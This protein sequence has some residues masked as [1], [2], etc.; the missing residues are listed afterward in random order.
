MKTPSPLHIAYDAKRAFFNRSGLGNYSRDLIRL[1]SQHYPDNEYY[2]FKPKDEERIPFEINENTSVITPQ[3][4]ISKR[5]ASLWRMLG[6]SFVLKNHPI[7]IYHGLSHDLP[8]R[9]NKSSVKS[10]VTIHDCIYKRFPKLYDRFSPFVYTLKQKYACKMADSIIA[11]SEQ[12][13]QDIIFYY[14]VPEEKIKVVYQGCNKSFYHPKTDEEKEGIKA[15]YQLP[16][17]FILNV[18]TIEERKN[19]LGILKALVEGNI[20]MPVVALGPKTKYFETVDAYA[21]QHK[22]DV[23]FIHN[24]NFSELPAIY[25]LAEVFIYPSKFEGF[26]IPIL[27]ALNSK[28]PIITTKG[29]VFP[30]VGGDAALYVEYG[31]EKQMAKTISRVLSDFKLRNDMVDKGLKQALKFREESIA[32][33]LMAVYQDVL[34]A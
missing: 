2:L 9:I 11:I 34:N 18:G 10:V 3:S 27:E 29:G 31:N 28:T 15:K 13:K 20:D 5:F 12:T 24:A 22:L 16:E 8:F 32:K 26:G 7:Q 33:N 21:K 1:I 30:E 25:Q 23:R 19:L 4:S 17:R 6:I 14:N